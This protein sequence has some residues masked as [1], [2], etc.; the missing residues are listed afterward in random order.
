VPPQGSQAYAKALSKVDIL[1]ADEAETIITG[2][3][4]VASEWEARLNQ[5][6]DETFTTNAASQSSLAPWLASCTAGTVLPVKPG[7]RLLQGRFGVTITSR[8]P[9]ATALEFG[10]D[11]LAGSSLQVLAKIWL[12]AGGFFMSLVSP[13]ISDVHGWTRQIRQR[14]HTYMQYPISMLG[15][16]VAVAD[17]VYRTI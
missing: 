2:L 1:T 5:E 6:R 3:S 12:L 17:A 4:T 8:L 9:S 7:C 15:R 13:G 10:I 16:S 11:P 14:L